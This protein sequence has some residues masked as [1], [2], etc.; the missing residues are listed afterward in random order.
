METVDRIDMAKALYPALAKLR[1]DDAL[2]AA[3]ITNAIAA[4]AEGYAFPTNLDRD[5]PV[6]GLAPKSQAAIMAEMLD[7]G[8]NA[9]DFAAALD[10][11]EA[12]RAS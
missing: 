6:G 1:S 12:K 2:T 5:P 7:A 9:A 8:A 10:R 11:M 4:C 3:E